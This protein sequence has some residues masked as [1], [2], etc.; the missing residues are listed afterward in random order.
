M[1]FEN[2]AAQ[3][4]KSIL[5]PSGFCKLRRMYSEIGFMEIKEIEYTF[6]DSHFRE[7]RMIK[8]L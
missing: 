8:D 7:M 6:L 2:P 1:E 3:Y 4:A 5:E